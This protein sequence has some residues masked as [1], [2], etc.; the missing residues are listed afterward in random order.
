MA[1]TAELNPA[2]RA[3]M[4]QEFRNGSGRQAE[5]MRRRREMEHEQER[6]RAE[7][8][9]AAT[10]PT[11]APAARPLVQPPA[12]GPGS[13]QSFMG[14]AAKIVAQGGVPGGAK[15]AP[16]ALDKAGKPTSPLAGP[17]TPATMQAAKASAQAAPVRAGEAEG[18][19]GGIGAKIL[20]NLPQGI[21]H[22]AGS[23]GSYVHR[24]QMTNV[25]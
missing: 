14:L 15:L 22:G 1:T 2:A 12:A 13:P 8:A 16:P 18:R 24:F 3:R 23:V 7:A 4:I 25:Q 6:R 10:R 19:P 21:L 9:Q 11:P 20:A 17:L 5:W